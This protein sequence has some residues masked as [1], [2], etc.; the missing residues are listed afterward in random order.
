VVAG[1]SPTGGRDRRWEEEE[2][3]EEMQQIRDRVAAL[4]VHR[5]TVAACAGVPGSRGGVRLDK[6]RFATTTAGVA[7]LAAWLAERGVTTVGMEA[8]GV[9]V[10]REGA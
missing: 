4:D 6:E 10:R 3:E 8:T 9:Y 7:Q 5:D 2:E 1:P